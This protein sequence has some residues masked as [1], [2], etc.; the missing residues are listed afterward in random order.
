MKYY[1]LVFS[2]LLTAC[3]NLPP[4][5]KDPPANDLAYLEAASN[6]AKYKNA[7]IRW[8]GK[9]VEVENEPTYSALQIL[10]LPLSRHG[11]PDIDEV[12]QGR[13]VVQSKTF[14]DPAVYKKDTAVTIAGSIVGDTERKIGNKTVHL[15][16]VSPNNVYLWQES[17]YARDYG[18]YYGGFG[19][20]YGGGYGYPYGGFY[21]YGPYYPGAFYGYSPYF[22]GG[23]YYSPYHR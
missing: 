1:F 4:A 14:L 15:P 21:G 11:R 22:R 7:P 8:G 6:L 19:Y 5:I 16:L 9:I 23:G 20:G 13:F 10:A 12:G 2:L 17:A 18:G 3:S